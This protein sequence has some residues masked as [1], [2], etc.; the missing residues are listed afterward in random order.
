MPEVKMKLGSGLSDSIRRHAESVYPAEACGLVL[1]QAE[2]GRAISFVSLENQLRGEDA[3]HGFRVCELEHLA[4]LQRGRAKGLRPLAF[5]HSHPDSSA[6]LSS[7]DKRQ[8][9]CDG[10]VLNPNV[11]QLV[12]SVRDGRLETMLAHRLKTGSMEAYRA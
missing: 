12:A 9:Y 1:G 5:F 7:R 2:S 11:I 8:L 6:H 10:E 4:A 3:K